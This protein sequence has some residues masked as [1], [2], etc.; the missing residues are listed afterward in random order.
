MVSQKE[1]SNMFC[2]D[3]IP[4][5]D[6]W[7][8][9]NFIVGIN[10]DME[11]IKNSTI[12]KIGN[13]VIEV[14][15][16]EK[17]LHFSLNDKRTVATLQLDAGN[18]IRFGAIK[19]ND[20]LNIYKGQFWICEN[21]GCKIEIFQKTEFYMDRGIFVCPECGIICDF[22]MGNDGDRLIMGLSPY[23][24]RIAPCHRDLYLDSRTTLG[25]GKYGWIDCYGDELS[26]E[27][28]VNKYRVEPEI[29]YDWVQKQKD[30]IC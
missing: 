20:R 27:D 13:Y 22:I 1:D 30:K 5:K 18:K 19:E 29:H 16:K 11:W 21:P 26:K 12:K 25:P 4:G 10:R 28:F 23:S 8:F 9:I 2:W 3:A 7:R 6:Y 24:M 14:S 17:S 15:T